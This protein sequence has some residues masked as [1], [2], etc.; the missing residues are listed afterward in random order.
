MVEIKNVNVYGLDKSI[1][2]SH[3][4][5]S[6]INWYD[7]S[8]PKVV[9]DKDIQRAVRLGKVSTGTGHDS[10]LKGI[11]V[12]FDIKYPQY[13]IPEADRYHWFDIVSSQTKSFTLKFISIEKSIN[14]YVD[15]KSLDIMNEYREKWLENPTYDN[16]IR[17]LSNVVLGYEMI[18]GI[19]TNYLQLK[20]MYFQRKNHRLK[21]DWGNFI[22]MCEELP[23]FLEII[24]EKK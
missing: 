23:L 12:Q 9:L 13:W 19:T 6:T 24:G 11:I 10:F 3:Y 7:I 15:Q 5:K 16:Y 21:E 17:L 14:K 1:L 2:D 18:M 8:T 20:T 22:K 4:P